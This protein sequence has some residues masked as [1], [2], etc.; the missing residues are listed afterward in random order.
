MV[1][2][3]DAL[4]TSDLPKRVLAHTSDPKAARSADA[5]RSW[6]RDPAPS[7]R[8]ASVRRI[9]SGCVA[10]P[11]SMGRPGSG[12]LGRWLDYA[13]TAAKHGG[14][15]AAP[16]CVSMTFLSSPPASRLRADL[17]SPWAWSVLL[18]PRSA[19]VVQFTGNSSKG[20]PSERE[21]PP[22]HAR[23]LP[24]LPGPGA[25]ESLSAGFAY[26]SLRS[27]REIRKT[28]AELPGRTPIKGRVEFPKGLSSPSYPFR[29][30]PHGLR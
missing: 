14:G 2:R 6:N 21:D 12:G 7:F 1:I 5:L 11:L 10:S 23:V 20:R 13:P 17:G 30:T 3:P 22:E 26:V 4:S 24:R 15:S 18:L 27:S 9:P 16:L 8:T 25:R 19:N 28:C 29:M